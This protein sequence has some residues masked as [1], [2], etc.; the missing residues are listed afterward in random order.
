MKLW[1][2]PTRSLQSLQKSKTIISIMTIQQAIK[3][4]NSII[5]STCDTIVLVV[6]GVT[7]LR[8]I[9]RLRNKVVRNSSK[10]IS[11]QGVKMR[12]KTLN[13]HQG[14]DEQQGQRYSRE[15]NIKI[16]RANIFVTTSKP[17]NDQF[18]L[19]LRPTVSIALI[20]LCSTRF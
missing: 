7:I 12:T 5:D 4:H 14:R 10:S 16:H 11:N 18:L 1:E 13:K 8:L 17:Q 3:E 20:P 9:F 15:E 19:D 6:L 2:H